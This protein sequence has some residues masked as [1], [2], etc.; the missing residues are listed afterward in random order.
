MI[1]AAAGG[2]G[3]G[4]RVARSEE[5]LEKLFNEAK[6]E[7]KTAFGDETVFFEKFIDEPK[8]I[9][10]QI[11][12]DKHGNLVHLFERDC[13]VQ[14]RFQKVIEIAPAPDLAQT[15]KDKLYEYAPGHW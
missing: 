13:S 1:K 15:I 2:G 4:M 8:H 11:L 9:E 7:A 6:R 5:G 14:R 12:G 3:R 10:I